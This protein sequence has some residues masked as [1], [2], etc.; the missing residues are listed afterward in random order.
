MSSIVDRA[1]ASRTLG[2]LVWLA[3]VGIVVL[4]VVPFFLALPLL[5]PDE[6]L[7]AAIAQEMVE[8]G[9]HLVPRFLGEPFFDKP[10][11]FFWT[12]ALSLRVFGMSEA[13][14][15]FPGVML[16]ALG[17]ATTGILAWRLFGRARTGWL[18]AIFYAT[19]DLPMALAEAPVHDVALVPFTTL[20]L[21]FF[22][23]SAGAGNRSLAL[24]S[25]GAAGI[26]LGIAILIKG[27][28]GV[29]L[30]CIGYGLFLL[31]S[32]RVSLE[33]MI[34]ILVAVVI[35]AAISAPW[36]V[37]M[38]LRHPGYARYF[39]LERHVSG[40]LTATQTH[41][42]AP[43]WYYAPVV[44][45]GGLPWIPL[46]LVALGERITAGR[47]SRN[48]DRRVSLTNEG[49]DLMWIWLFGG[50]LFLS[51]A[52]SKLVTYVLPLFPSIAILAARSVDLSLGSRE[53]RT[54]TSVI[55][56]VGMCG[57]VTVP[58]VLTVVAWRYDYNANTFVW[59]VGTLL[60]AAWWLAVWMWVRGRRLA[61]TAT[62]TAIQLAT[63]L[64]L[65][66]LVVPAVAGLLSARDLA[67]HFN[68]LQRLPRQLLIADERVG[69][70]VFYLD[71]D[72]RLKAEQIRPVSLNDFVRTTPADPD[73]VLALP[74]RLVDK[75]RRFWTLRDVPS[76][77]VGH[78]R[79]FNARDLQRQRKLAR[80][81][82]DAPA[83][84]E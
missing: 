38:D 35:G 41:G 70:I 21:L 9:D 24:R 55:T 33:A 15:R 8:R 34:S 22:W 71:P 42:E 62:A 14:V 82:A 29:A 73:I 51:L 18:A 58:V 69:S 47:T 75:A 13:A 49:G 28:T 12:Q 76:V 81:V 32:R 16:G 40:F 4:Y 61:A 5:D 30:V 64:A 11:F 26:A 68:R 46:L 78:Y 31:W 2:P 65:L 74:L 27:L 43:W 79:L 80:P 57:F 54:A 1:Q 3:V 7:H 44:V 63:A 45:G 52:H 83:A 39:F 67:H 25:A 36:Y 48:A 72:L 6:G 77:T 84:D 59:T 23:N 20:A 19:M 56:L 10:A 17:A 37:L 60:S 66:A 50:L 53:S